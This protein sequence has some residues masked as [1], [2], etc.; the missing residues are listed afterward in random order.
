M[1]TNQETRGRPLEGQ[2][3]AILV[4]D[5]FEQIEMTEPRQALVNA[6]AIT[7][8]IA[9]VTGL[10]RSWDDG[11]WAEEFQVDVP[12]AQANA[13]D[14]DAL[15]IP[16]G[17]MSP[18]K[19]R[20][21]ETAVQFVREFFDDEKP[22]AS[23]CHGPW[24]LI[25]A[26]VAEGRTLTSYPSLRRDLENAGADWVDGKAV[27]DDKLVTSRNP[28]DLPDFNKKMIEVF[29]SVNTTA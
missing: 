8:L 13:V 11:N 22:V 17:V 23:I 5:G 14:Y 28:G 26:E 1:E 4:A 9:P 3:V 7:T 19:L 25:E 24:L 27:V 18:D 10:V 6:G 29:S 15:L 2:Q 20:M 16:G 21:S 12:L